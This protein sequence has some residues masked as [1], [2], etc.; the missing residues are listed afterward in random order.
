MTTVSAE[1]TT[2]LTGNYNGLV[3]VTP[4]SLREPAACNNSYFKRKPEVQYPVSQHSVT[5]SICWV[6]FF[7]FGYYQ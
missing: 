4:C 7:F 3:V 5:H 6:F 1:G 2:L